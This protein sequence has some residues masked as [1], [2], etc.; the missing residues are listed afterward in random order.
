MFIRIELINLF[1]SIL[2]NSH[3]YP[4]KIVMIVFIY[5]FIIFLNITTR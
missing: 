4:L 1:Y 2:Y 5:L 3:K